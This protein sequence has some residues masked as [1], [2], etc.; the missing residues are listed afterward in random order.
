MLTRYTGHQHF[1]DVDNVDQAVSGNAKPSSSKP[2][3]AFV[4]N[5]FIIR[6]AAKFNAGDESGDCWGALAD[7][8]QADQL[9]PNDLPTLQLRA[10]VRLRLGDAR[11]CLDDLHSRA[12]TADL[13]MIRGYASSS[14][15]D[16]E[17]ALED[18]VAADQM[19]PNAADEV[20]GALEDMLTANRA[21][22][23]RMAK[24]T[25]LR[26]SIHTRIKVS[27]CRPQY[28]KITFLCLCTVLLCNLQI[29]SWTCTPQLSQ[30]ING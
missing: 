16:N 2:D 25:A 29:R 15:G 5:Q 10:M 8:N 13:L 11:G 7:L 26:H 27:F 28:I 21:P 30:R 6:A 9:Q 1:Q 17:Q 3:A 20:C 4:T 22:Q 19:C 24:L 14:I 12:D 18:L 23:L